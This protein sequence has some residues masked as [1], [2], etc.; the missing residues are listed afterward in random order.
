LK[1]YL[2][3]A[4]FET[5]RQQNVA[6]LCSQLP[7]IELVDAIYPS[8][9]KIPFI[10]DIITVSAQRTG[11]ALL[12][13]EIG[14]LLSHRKIWQKI[15]LADAAEKAHFLILESDSVLNMPAYFNTQ[16]AALALSQKLN[17]TS[18]IT[19]KQ[20]NPQIIEA[21]DL[22]FWGAWDGYMQLFQSTKQP[23]LQGFQYG[24]PFI[25]T[26]YCTYGYSL[27]KKAASM[28][29]H[30]TKH[31]AYPVDQFKRYLQQTDLKIGG[32]VPELIS[33]CGSKSHIREKKSF[34][35][36]NHLFL[37]LLTIKNKLICFFK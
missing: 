4:P 16:N 31:I 3:S 23:L 12:L 24:E 10:N 33:T 17:L 9:Q 19:S 2:L 26:I 35:L 37:L 5:D 29:L 25:K 6:L 1:T 32:V 14:C 8:K 21:H 36:F 30:K 13:G 15:L 7:E 34:K 28:L 18:S 11:K 22:F 27:N 20:L